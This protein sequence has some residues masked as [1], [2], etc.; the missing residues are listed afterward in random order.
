MLS[1]VLGWGEIFLTVLRYVMEEITRSRLKKEMES[2]QKTR[3]DNAINEWDNTL[4][5]GVSDDD[6]D[7]FRKAP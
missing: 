2:D 6:P 5:S 4:G 1:K 3:V 7:L